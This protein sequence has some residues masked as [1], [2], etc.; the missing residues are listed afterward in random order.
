[1]SDQHLLQV[2]K[3][4]LDDLRARGL[5]KHERRIQGPQGAAIRVGERDAINFCANN[6]LGLANHAAVVEAA[7]EGLRRWGY[8]LSS[9]R[10][11]CGTQELHRRLETA[12][13]HFLGK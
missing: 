4:Q 5:Y 9:V 6:Y 12:V 11:I 2:L 1:M 7:H 10:F 8:G 3:P 13:A